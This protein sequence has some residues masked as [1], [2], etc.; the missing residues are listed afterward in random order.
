MK[1]FLYVD[2]DR[3]RRSLLAQL[4]G[5]LIEGLTSETAKTLEGVASASLFGIGGSG[6]YSREARHQE[7][8][9]FQEMVF[10]AFE[11]LADEQELI[12]DLG[13]EV[14]QVDR[15]NSG[16]VHSS[17]SDGQIV[18]MTCDLQILDG[19]LFRSRLERFDKLV[20]GF[21]A[22]TGGDVTPRNTT[23]K[24]RAQMGAMAKAA[25]MGGTTPALLN[26][27]SDFVDAF[28]GDDISFRALACG[29]EHLSRGF[30]GTLLGRR[31]YI[32]EKRESLLSRYGTVASNWTSVMQVAAIPMPPADPEGVTEESALAD[33]LDEPQAEDDANDSTSAESQVVDDASGS[34]DRAVMENL[35]VGLLGE[36]ERIG[37]V[38]GPRWP[39]ISVTPLAVYRTIPG[40]RAPE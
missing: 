31:G 33:A 34:I 1:E 32:Q 28:V 26:A 21:L 30:G 3:T 40:G 39:T 23:P 27:I 19:S 12:T 17:L 7:S 38:E 25:L 20:D 24:Q 14:G 9:S 13:P 15:W 10:V 22:I 8:R 16:D 6:G 29:S 2:V 4:Q 35:A 36:M 5:G 11:A 18:R 37:V